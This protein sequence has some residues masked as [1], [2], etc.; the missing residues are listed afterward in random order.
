MKNRDFKKVVIKNVADFG[1][2]QNIFI[3]TQNG[4]VADFNNVFHLDYNEE[5]KTL[6]IY[7]WID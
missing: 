7:H 1:G 4:N 6:E 5:E 2:F 3:R